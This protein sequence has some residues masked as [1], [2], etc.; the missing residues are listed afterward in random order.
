[1]N[2]IIQYNGGVFACMKLYSEEFG[3]FPINNKDIRNYQLLTN[4]SIENYTK[5]RLPE[6]LKRIQN[7]CEEGL[8]R[9]A[10]FPDFS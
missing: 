8:N 2:K 9:N 3:E 7:L 10:I 6:Y 5:N 1:M 4:I